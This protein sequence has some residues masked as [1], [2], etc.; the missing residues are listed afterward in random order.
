MKRNRIKKTFSLV[1]DMKSY[2]IVYLTILLSFMY[3][4]LTVNNYFSYFKQF[5]IFR[6]DRM[7]LFLI[8]LSYSLS[9]F[10]TFKEI[11]KNISVLIR[12][13]D[14]KSYLKYV[15]KQEINAVLVVFILHILKS[16]I[17]INLFSWKNF[18]ID[19][20]PYYNFNI[21]VYIVINLLKHFVFLLF[22]VMII[23]LL[24]LRFS[25]IFGG[26]ISVM[27]NIII[28]Y[29]QNFENGYILN[30]L[31]YLNFTNLLTVIN[32]NGN[33][34]FEIM[35]FVLYI[36]GLSYICLI[37]VTKISTNFKKGILE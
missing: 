6:T 10:I 28:F 26:I 9:I 36:I 14:K 8:F 30:K 15:I 25:E 16:L 33:L 12:F 5:L 2:K 37:L 11:K 7:Y 13:K 22:Y 19:L 23:T 32:Y 4:F 17:I 1:L 35:Y 31:E 20:A 18:T 21:L 34:F 27:F 29:T 3:E 24:N